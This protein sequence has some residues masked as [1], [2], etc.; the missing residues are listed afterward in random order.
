[1]SHLHKA[2][3]HQQAHAPGIHEL[4]EA[5]FCDC[6]LI[7]LDGDDDTAREAHHG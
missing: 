3:C 2:D 4:L 7:L 1:M 5:A 6:R